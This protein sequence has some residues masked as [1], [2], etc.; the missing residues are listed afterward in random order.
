M[1][2]ALGFNG[3][4]EKL[5]TLHGKLQ[6]DLGDLGNARFEP[7]AVGFV[8]DE[9]VSDGGEFVESRASAG[10]KLQNP[11]F[12]SPEILHAGEG[13]EDK[14][15]VHPFPLKGGLQ[16]L[17]KGAGLLRGLHQNHP[18]VSFRGGVVLEKKL[19]PPTFS[20]G[21]T[22]QNSELR[23]LSKAAQLFHQI[24]GRAV[25]AHIDHGFLFPK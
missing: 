15:G 22:V 18:W 3:G 10:V 1:V 4:K 16:G 7:F 17:G 25:K 6:D 14:T 5:A 13:L 2:S 19:A 11:L 23:C 20:V 21:K 12:V 9:P 8:L 24:V